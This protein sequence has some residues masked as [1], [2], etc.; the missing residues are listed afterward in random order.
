MNEERKLE[1]IENLRSDQNY[2]GSY[3]KQFLS[4]SDVGTLLYNPKLFGKSRP[5]SKNLAEGRLFHQLLLEP[6]KAKDVLFVDVTTRNT[7]KYREYCEEHNAEFVLLKKEVDDV[8]AMVKAMTSN[9]QFYDAIYEAGNLYEEPAI[10]ELHGLQWKGKADIVSRN[11]VIDLK[12]TSDIHKFRYKA[13]AY[14]YDSQAYLYQTM[15]GKPLVF[16]VVDKETHQ[17]GIFHPTED[18]ITGGLTKVQQAVD[19]Y[20]RFFGDNAS[21]AVQNH[22]IEGFLT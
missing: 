19:V 11:Y 2:Y 7:N 8:K 21:E 6:D 15:F 10:T 9:I 16:Y 1:A 18:F 4:N 12:T 22:F 3:G 13:K 14:N 5:D 20:V 17:L